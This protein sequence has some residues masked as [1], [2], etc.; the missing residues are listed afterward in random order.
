MR[1][2]FL[3]L[4]PSQ[5][6]LDRRDR[7]RPRR[8]GSRIPASDPVHRSLRRE[9]APATRVVSPPSSSFIASSRHQINMDGSCNPIGRIDDIGLRTVINA[10]GEILLPVDP[11]STHPLWDLDES[12]LIGIE[13]R[14]PE[15]STNGTVM[16]FHAN[17]LHSDHV[18]QL[19]SYFTISLIHNSIKKFPV[20][21]SCSYKL[22]SL[23][24]RPSSTEAR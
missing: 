3:D 13:A 18:V 10:P 22:I 2:A 15:G 8:L 1:W 21:L 11:L 9:S 17:N 6:C 5:F 14:Y 20:D 4:N 12:P 16:Q 23:L 19:A 24:F 7:D